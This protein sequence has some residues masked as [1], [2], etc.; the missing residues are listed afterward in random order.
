MWALELECDIGGIY[1]ESIY[2]AAGLMERERT[3]IK[4]G[5]GQEGRGG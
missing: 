4:V 1:K 2:S 5:K 3:P